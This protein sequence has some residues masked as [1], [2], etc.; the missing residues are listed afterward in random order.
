MAIA[1]RAAGAWAVGSTSVAPTIP[2]GAVAGDVL[3]MFVSVSNTHT[4]T[5]PSG[6]TKRGTARSAF[7]SVT[8]TGR[9]IVAYTRTCQA[10]DPGTTVTVT[11]S[12]ST[13]ARAVVVAYSGVD[14]ADPVCGG[15][16]T[17]PH[18]GS[19][20]AHMWPFI[21]PFASSAY[22][23]L[24][25]GTT[26]T[27]LT[28]VPTNFT[29]AANTNGSNNGGTAS[30]YV[31]DRMAADA[32]DAIVD[33]ADGT[34]AT[35][36]VNGTETLLLVLKDAAA[37]RANPNTPYVRSFHQ[38]QGDGVANNGVVRGVVAPGARVGD[39]LTAVI[40]LA[41]G[42]GS[43]GNNPSGW[44]IFAGSNGASDLVNYYQLEKLAAEAADQGGDNH[45]WT[46]ISGVTVDTDVMMVS[47]AGAGDLQ[48]PG[49]GT[50]SATT[51][52]PVLGGNASS[53]DQ[54]WLAFV[55]TNRGFST[56]FTW[57]AGWS[58]VGGGF[59]ATTRTAM[60]WL[61]KR[62]VATAGAVATA[63]GTLSAA[64]DGLVVV[65]PYEPANLPPTAPT[66]VA[67]ANAAVENL[68]AGFT[69]DWTPNDADTGD[70]QSAYA[71]RRKI[72][73]AGSYEYWNAS[74]SAWQSSEVWNTG[75]ATEVTFAASK[76]VNGNI[77]NWSVAT[78]DAAGLAGP[79]ASD[80]TVTGNAP[81][82]V[83]PTAPT[84]TV[85]DTSRPAV[86]WSFSDPEGTAQQR[87]EVII[88]TGAY[89]TTPGSGTEV[90]D[91]GEVTSTATSVTPN[92][93]LADDTTF[94]AFSRV[95]SGSQWSAWGYTTFT[96]D[97]TP[98]GAPTLSAVADATLGRVA[99]TVTPTHSDVD[100]PVASTIVEY[101]D[102]AGAT[103]T[104]V[105][106]GTLYYPAG[107][108][109]VTVYDYEAQ[110]G[111]ARQYRARTLAE[112]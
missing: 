63:N 70:T 48:D 25:A 12:A 27:T 18:A 79:Y 47:I 111:I 101:S 35:S 26:S 78:K 14:T 34:W 39:R 86:T 57:P 62:R 44:E 46:N 51:T 110:P 42:G 21:N 31:V 20:T 17:Q 77:Y 19:V 103:W 24:L 54:L 40:A 93:D 109:A 7:S 76:W 61:A 73:G 6:W 28:T 104:T 105:R 55:S 82:T 5:T 45:D 36:Q 41:N 1:R 13:D 32:E 15:S 23:A 96:L 69:F 59:Q 102:D 80:F 38:R 89:G 66:L 108:A 68:A 100:F 60:T 112:V 8:V 92:V 84:G 71:F 43:I 33:P 90:Y 30:L 107:P 97:L 64:D 99:I 85:T 75:T 37:V 10:G 29:T 11:P 65:L 88:E 106:G 9:H 91:S 83:T 72:S 52:V 16:I 67:P 87:Y 81:P 56:T 74:T 94:R 22:V 4:I 3:V 53:D 98:P 95:R 2:A 50:F 49:S 58:P